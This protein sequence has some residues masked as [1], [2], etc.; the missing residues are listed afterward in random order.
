MAQGTELHVI[1]RLPYPRPAIEK[2]VAPAPQ[3]T[4]E[5]DA[6][7]LAL[8]RQTGKDIIDDPDCTRF[9]VLPSPSMPMEAYFLDSHRGDHCGTAW[10]QCCCV[11]ATRNAASVPPVPAKGISTVREHPLYPSFLKANNLTGST[12]NAGMPITR[13]RGPSA[14]IARGKYSSSW[15]SAHGMIVTRTNCCRPQHRVTAAHPAV[16]SSPVCAPGS[17]NPKSWVLNPTRTAA[18]G[19]VTRSALEDAFLSM[20]LTSA[21][22]ER[23]KSP[24]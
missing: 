19:S 15:C 3:W 18:G 1:V 5:R 9:G 6:R 24:E 17:E 4:Q 12:T 16:T 10:G 20:S 22:A 21:S 14:R 7:L 23:A 11:L 13:R 8:M 2:Q